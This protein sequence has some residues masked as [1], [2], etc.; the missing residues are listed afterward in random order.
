VLAKRL[1]VYVI[2]AYAI[3]LE[4]GLGRH[5]S[6]VMQACFSGLLPLQLALEHLKRVSAKVS[7]R[8]LSE[9]PAR[10]RIWTAAATDELARVAVDALEKP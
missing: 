5:I 1:T 7:C 9:P 6:R 10:P 4:N 3:A 8:H 2:G